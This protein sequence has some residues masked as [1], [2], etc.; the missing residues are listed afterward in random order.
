MSEEAFKLKAGLSF[1]Q[2]GQ[3]SNSSSESLHPVRHLE[4]QLQE[5]ERDLGEPAGAS[6]LGFK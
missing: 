4:F 3:A 5:R 1:I 6:K 2:V